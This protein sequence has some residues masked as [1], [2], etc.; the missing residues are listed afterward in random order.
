[1]YLS[2]SGCLNDFAVCKINGVIIYCKFKGKK[3]YSYVIFV[4]LNGSFY[5]NNRVCCIKG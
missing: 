5:F 4:S 3:N 2:V 1:M